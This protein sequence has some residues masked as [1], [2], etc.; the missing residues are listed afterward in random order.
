MKQQLSDLLDSFSGFLRTA[1]QQ[2][3]PNMVSHTHTHTHTCTSVCEDFHEP[4]DLTS[5][6]Y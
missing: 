1:Q 3:D 5:M 4:N 6:Q 2:V